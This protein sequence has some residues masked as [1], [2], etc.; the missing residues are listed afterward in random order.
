MVLVFSKS[1]WVFTFAHGVARKFDNGDEHNQADDDAEDPSNSSDL[2]RVKR[3]PTSVEDSIV[4][5][6]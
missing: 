2:V 1:C 3:R 4:A 6:L 5:T